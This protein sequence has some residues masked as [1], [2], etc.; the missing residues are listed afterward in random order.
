MNSAAYYIVASIVRNTLAEIIVM[1][2]ALNII[3]LATSDENP[4]GF[5]E[6]LFEGFNHLARV[7][8]CFGVIN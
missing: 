4:G 2:Y 6:H 1:K 3:E 7:R 5:A 8:W